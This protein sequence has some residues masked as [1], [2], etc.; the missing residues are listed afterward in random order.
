MMT[1]EQRRI[2]QREYSRKYRLRKADERETSLKQSTPPPAAPTISMR[3]EVEKSI[4][5]MKWIEPSDG[6][7]V[8]LA[9]LYGA[10]IDELLANGDS[11]LR[12]KAMRLSQQLLRVLHELGGTPR[13]RLQHELRSRRLGLIPPSSPPAIED[14]SISNVSAFKRPAK[15]STGEAR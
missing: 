1:D 13:V 8:A 3:Q 11:A 7:A 5:A 12:M 2:R 14:K 9:R 4:E 6:A 10:Q 15:R